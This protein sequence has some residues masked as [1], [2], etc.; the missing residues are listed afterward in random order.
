[1]TMKF[2]TPELFVRLNSDNDDEID[3]AEADWEAARKKYQ[4]HF[5]RIEA[6]LPRPLV[7]LCNAVPLHDAVVERPRHLAWTVYENDDRG[8][9]SWTI[10]SVRQPDAAY[11]LV[12]LDPVEPSQ[13]NRLVD[14]PVF[15]E[16]N[17]IW[18]YDEVSYQRG[19]CMHEILFSNGVVLTIRFKGF[20]YAE[21]PLVS[22]RLYQNADAV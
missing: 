7:K 4:K 2:F 9:H 21:M 22:R 8:E 3:Q 20:K 11:D 10:L 16:E 5:K 15:T 1:M 13:L 18:L 19:I 14:S 6:K 17:V 12:Y